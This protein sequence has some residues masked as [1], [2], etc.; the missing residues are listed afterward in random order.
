MA[1]DLVVLA[2]VV[3]LILGAA[4]GTAAGREADRRST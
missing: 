2:V 1:C 4:K 3:R